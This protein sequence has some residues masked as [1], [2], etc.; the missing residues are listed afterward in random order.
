[1]SP[2]EARNEPRRG[3]DYRMQGKVYEAKAKT[4]QT[5]ALYKRQGSNAKEQ[6]KKL[7]VRMRLEA[8]EQQT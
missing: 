3:R 7:P 6:H 1:M 5:K 8:V 4:L 2:E